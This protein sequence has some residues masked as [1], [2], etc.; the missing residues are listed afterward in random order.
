M[1][2]RFAGPV[3]IF[4]ILVFSGSPGEAQ[5][6]TAEAMPPAPTI[7]AVRLSDGDALTL[8]G[9]LDESIYRT[10]TPFSGFIQQEPTAGA[11]ATEDTQVW[12]FFDDRNIYLGFRCLDSQPERIVANEMRR[13]NNNIYQ[14]DTITFIF[15]TFLDRRTA[16]YFQTNPLGALRDALVVSENTTNYDWSTVWDV[17]AQM[18]SGGWSLEIVIPFKS[19]RYPQTSEQTW[20][21]NVRRFLRGKNEQSL[22]SPVPRSYSGSGLQRISSAATLVGVEPPPASRNL[23]LKPSLLSNVTTN[24]LT[25]PPISNDLDGSFSL[26]AKYGITNNITA[27]VTYNTDFA[28]VE[29]DEQQ[30]NLTRFSL[31]FP[32]KR[33]FFLEGQNVFDFAGTGVITSQPDAPILFFSRRIGLNAGVPV[34]IRAGGRLTGRMGRT[35]IGVL[36]IGTEDSSLAKAAA[37]NFFVTRVKQDILRRSSIGLVATRRTPSLSGIGSNSAFGVDANLAFFTNLQINS[38]YAR[39]QTPGTTGDT[40]SYRGQFRYNADRYALELDRVKVGQGFNPEVGFVRRP[41]VTRSYMLARFSPRPKRIPGVRKLGVE[42]SYERFVDGAGT[43]ESRAVQPSFR[44]EFESSDALNVTYNANYEFLESPFRIA[45]GVTI[46][47]GAYPF[48]DLQA[49]YQIGPQRTLSGTVSVGRGN[50]YSGHR[51]AVGYAGRVKFSSQLAVE[52]RVSVERVRLLQGSFTTKLA[53]ARTTYTIS[54]RMFASALVQYNS[55]LNTLE[56]NARFRWEYIPGS[57][58]F[59]VYTDG[60]DTADPRLAELVNRGFA[61]KLTRLFRF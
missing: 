31:F 21:F 10:S 32:E 9:R 34:P 58:L 11:P 12:L 51:T 33:D 47:V 30:V 18:D 22:L 53:G 59:V 40:E 36:D 46:P 44:M 27:D 29:I 37:T 42:V 6:V 7:R 52:P 45:S 50:F 43:L 4:L 17:R 16:F 13:D 24:R 5:T 2:Q 48:S 8:D 14:N 57:D 56:T 35:S 19:L 49:S 60:R 20:G 55:S 23:E 41:D 15:D 1:L 61:V 26:D 28:Q 54:P 25:S 39:T 3:S 38:Y